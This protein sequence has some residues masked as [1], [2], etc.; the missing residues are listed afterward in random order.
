MHWS[1]GYSISTPNNRISNN[2]VTCHGT[3][4]LSCNSKKQI[5]KQLKGGH[6]LTSY[7]T[8]TRSMVLAG[9]ILASANLLKP[10]KPKR[11]PLAQKRIIIT[12]GQTM[13]VI[14]MSSPT[15]IKAQMCFRD[16]VKGM[17]SS[18]VQLVNLL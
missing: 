9:I 2:S 12:G 14:K 17:Q 8:I 7:H 16:I 1:K 6:S 5:S 4:G 10:M 18:K 11:Q 15:K 13:N 3:T